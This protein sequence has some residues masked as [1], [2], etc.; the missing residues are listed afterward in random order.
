LAVLATRQGVA[1]STG[2]LVDALWGEDPPPSAF[3]ALQ[4]YVWSLRKRLPAGSI[5]TVAGGYRA[6]VD[7]GAVDAVVFERLVAAARTRAVD[8][9]VRA[10]NLL[11]EG[12]GLWRGVP[13]ADLGDHPFGVSEATRLLELRK[14]AEEDLVELRLA[15]GEHDQ[16]ISQLEAAVGAEPLRQR[17]WAQLMTASYRC[18]R[19]ADALRAYQRLR[20]TLAEELGIDPSPALSALESGILAHDPGLDIPTSTQRD[21]PAFTGFPSGTVTFLFT[22]M[23]GSSAGWDR[24][25]ATMDR[26]Q[27]RHDEILRNAIA[28]CGGYVFS[29]AGDGLGAA[30]CRAQDGLAA[31]VAARRELCAEP[32]PDLIRVSV[33]MGLHTGEVV[34]RGGNYFGPAVIRASRLMSA[35]NG[36]RI[37]CSLATEQLAHP[38]LPDDVEL[39]PAGTLALKGLALPEHVFVVRGLGLHRRA[40]R[41]AAY[42]RCAPA[43]AVDPA[44]RTPYRAGHGR[45]AAAGSVAGYP[46]RRR[47]CR[48]DPPG[49]GRRPSRSGQV[50]RRHLLG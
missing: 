49:Y 7:G 33:R 29:S 5:V 4:T 34:E 12:L 17:R 40:H 24:D 11:A 45:R 16:L 19:Q 1:V 32:W 23:E 50:P 21:T 8:A 37:V 39:V 31:A 47:R 43:S 30:F 26:A 38:H 18:D 20:T 9:P 27:A 25:E 22:D 13:L 15:A 41:V 35:V 14:Q 2:E 6:D 46:D 44:R 3:K 36:G 48:Q 42:S 10:A 28:R